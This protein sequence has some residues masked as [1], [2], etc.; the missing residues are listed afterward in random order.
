VAAATGNLSESGKSLSI[1]LVNLVGL[2]A[3]GVVTQ[4]AT[5]LWVRRVESG[6]ARFRPKPRHRS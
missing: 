4:L 1:L 6:R 5:R 3:G 2:L